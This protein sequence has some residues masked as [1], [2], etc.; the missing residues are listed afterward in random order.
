MSKNKNE[1]KSLLD[2]KLAS[3]KLAQKDAR[4]AFKEAQSKLFAEHREMMKKNRADMA[5]AW[6]E[7]KQNASKRK[8]VRKVE[9]TE[10]KAKKAEKCAKAEA[11]KPK[12]NAAEVI[13]KG[14]AEIAKFKKLATEKAAK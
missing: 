13:A 4:K 5:A 9:A 2:Q 6:A 14:E 8:A 1:S 10:L 11:S 3:I 12:V 7:Y